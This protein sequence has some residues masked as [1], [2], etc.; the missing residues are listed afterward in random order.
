ML[1]LFHREQG[2]MLITSLLPPRIPPLSP[3]S[4]AAPGF[5]FLHCGTEDGRHLSPGRAAAGNATR[6]RKS[7]RRKG[8]VFDTYGYAQNG[9]LRVKQTKKKYRNKELHKSTLTFFPDS[10]RKTP[11]RCCRRRQDVSWEPWQQREVATS[12]AATTTKTAAGKA[13][14]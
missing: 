7:Q 10:G 5:N 14:R 1:P 11:R 3:Q 9:C 13:V 4:P 2:L 12:I 6:M 8:G